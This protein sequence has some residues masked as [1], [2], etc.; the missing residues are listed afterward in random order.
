M[1]SF[2]FMGGRVGGSAARRTG[3]AVAETDVER[4]ALATCCAR[5]S[6]IASLL[7][8]VRPVIDRLDLVLD[9][10]RQRALGEVT[11]VVKSRPPNGG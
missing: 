1:R 8:Q 2:A 10:V 3:R 4:L 7:Q 9:C 6:I 5:A 11:R